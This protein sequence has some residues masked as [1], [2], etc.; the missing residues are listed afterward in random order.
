MYKNTLRRLINRAKKLYF[1]GQ[2]IKQRGKSRKTW[3]TLDN[4]LHKKSHKSLPD[5]VLIIVGMC[6]DKKNM[7]NAINEYFDTICRNNNPCNNS[8][9]YT[10]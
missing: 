2:L 1:L 5:G 8:V 7:S 9:P 10:N 4:A 6:N 3:Q